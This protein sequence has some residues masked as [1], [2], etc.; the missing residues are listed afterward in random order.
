M[1]FLR[2]PA[3]AADW[4]PPRPGGGAPAPPGVSMGE[5]T[6]GPGRRGASVMDGRPNIALVHGSWADCS[7]WSG[8]IERRQADG[9]GTQ[10]PACH[11]D[12][13]PVAD[14]GGA[15]GSSAQ[16]RAAAARAWPEPM[17]GQHQPGHAADWDAG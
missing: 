9:R 3:T 1:D 14:S 2:L 7:C 16:S 6:T 5:T 15:H 13:T 8:V 12:M 10:F 17:A 11:T 4:A